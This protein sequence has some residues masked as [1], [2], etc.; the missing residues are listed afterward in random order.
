MKTIKEK[1]TYLLTVYPSLRDNDYRLIAIFLLQEIGEIKVKQISA[2]DFLLMF[3]KG[4]LPHTES[5][6]RVRALIQAQ[7][8][9]LRGESY[10]NRINS[11]QITSENINGI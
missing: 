7:N 11:G 4:E 6:R 2:F 3:S 8:P 1:V 9:E 5:I 10:N